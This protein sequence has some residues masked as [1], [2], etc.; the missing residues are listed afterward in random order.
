MSTQL[1][2]GKP[3]LPSWWPVGFGAHPSFMA[4]SGCVG[5]KAP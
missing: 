1:A 4:V 3:V 5:Y 2:S